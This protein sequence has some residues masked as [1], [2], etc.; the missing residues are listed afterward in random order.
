M[1]EIV[2][3]RELSEK[4]ELFF[5]VL[6]AIF[7][8][9]CAQGVTDLWPVCGTAYRLFLN[10]RKMHSLPSE[11]S[12]EGNGVREKERTNFINTARKRRRHEMKSGE[13]KEKETERARERENIVL[14]AV[15][16]LDDIYF[17]NDP[18]QENFLVRSSVLRVP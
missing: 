18:G 13:K 3:G 17:G 9:S 1:S 6:P 7:A 2:D 14:A 12:S 15:D 8:Q 16:I 4:R 10:A 5:S 11:R